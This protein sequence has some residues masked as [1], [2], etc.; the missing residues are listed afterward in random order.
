MN[1][2]LCA[3]GL[4]G[5]LSLSQNVFAVRF[6]DVSTYLTSVSKAG[7][8]LVAVGEHGKVLLSED[9]GKHWQSV[10]GGVT[11]TLTAVRF[12]DDREGFALGHGGTILKTS[13]GGQTW[14]AVLQGAQVAELTREAAAR[15][16]SDSQLG[17]KASE[18]ELYAQ[19][20]DKSEASDPLFDILFFGTNK[21][22]VVGAYGMVLRSDDGGDTWQVWMAHV[23]NPQESHLYAIAQAGDAIYLAGEQGY[24]ARSLDQGRTFLKLKTDVGSSFFT[25]QVD[26]Q[27]KILAAGLQGILV[28]TV[29]QGGSWTRLD[30]GQIGTLID[31][32]KD[33]RGRIYFADL[34][35]RL[36]RLVGNTLTPVQNADL[37]LSAFVIDSEGA[38]VIVGASGIKRITVDKEIST[39]GAGHE[40]L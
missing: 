24:L 2:L 39:G 38:F 3:V 31:S 18:L 12:F 14:R 28:L 10:E 20:L 5:L 32:E 40:A 34:N 19:R 11:N 6:E 26:N 13:D 35:G 7:N 37:P 9:N 30:T 21:I 36:T 15:I 33:D 29:N 16:S 27:G 1:K 23:E 22:L 8:R 17:H 25:L 4:L